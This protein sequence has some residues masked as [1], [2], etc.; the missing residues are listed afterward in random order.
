MRFLPLLMAV[1]T[2]SLRAD[3]VRMDCHPEP[4]ANQQNCEARNCT[5]LPPPDQDKTIPW[6]FMKKG[7]GYVNVS[8]SGSVITLKKNNGPRN[9]WG[10]DI[11]HIQLKTDTFG[12]TLNVKIFVDGRY[13]PPVGLPRNPSVSADSLQ[14]NLI[15]CLVNYPGTCHPANTKATLCGN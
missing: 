13:D 7:I 1:I 2:S 5:W 10:D 14:V 8:S 6:C 4:D 3:N 12:K 15:N 11:D 9:P